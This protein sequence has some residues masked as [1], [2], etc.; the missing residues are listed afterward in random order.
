MHST[1]CPPRHDAGKREKGVGRRRQRR[2]GKLRSCVSVSLKELPLLRKIFL[3]VFRRLP[4]FP[5]AFNN[6]VQHGNKKQIQHR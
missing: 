5:P 1:E 6:Q 3:S 4:V 2:I